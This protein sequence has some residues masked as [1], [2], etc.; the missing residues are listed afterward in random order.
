MKRKFFFKVNVSCKNHKIKK[1]VLDGFRI[2]GWNWLQYWSTIPTQILL[3]CFQHLR[4]KTGLITQPSAWVPCKTRLHLFKE[5]H[6][7]PHCLLMSEL[8]YSPAG[9]KEESE[10][11]QL[12]DPNG[13]HWKQLQSRFDKC[14]LVCFY[15]V[16]KKIVR[17]FLYF[18]Y[19]L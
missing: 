7:P 10:Q 19:I 3:P 4:A 16:W 15:R 2:F 11:T 5:M 14:T 13:I 6:C 1:H 9:C 18:L 12:R 17:R 8:F